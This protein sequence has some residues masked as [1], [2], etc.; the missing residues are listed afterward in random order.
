VDLNFHGTDFHGTEE[1]FEQYALGRLAGADLISLEEHLLLCD[2]CQVRLDEIGPFAIGMREALSLQPAI[3]PS[4]PLKEW[5]AWLRRPAFAMAIACAAALIAIIAV[6]STGVVSTGGT[7]LAPTAMLQL[8]AIRGEM[9]ATSPAREY[10]LTLADA[11]RAGGPFRVEVVNGSGDSVWKGPADADSKGAE[12]KIDET[13]KQGD[14][15][16]RL[17]AASGQRLREYGFRIR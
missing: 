11:P 7:K 13:L 12:V 16:V 10:D 2:A 3:A 14:Y 5:F 6:V 1:Q 15:F 4:A 9:P 17:Y 8:T